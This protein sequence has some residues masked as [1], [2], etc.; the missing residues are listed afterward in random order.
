MKEKT[1]LNKAIA[2]AECNTASDLK[3]AHRAA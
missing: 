1:L 3:W 2:E